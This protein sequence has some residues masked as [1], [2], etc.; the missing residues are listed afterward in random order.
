MVQKQIGHGAKKVLVLH[1]WFGASV[2]DEFFDDFD[3]DKFR[4]AIVHNPGYGSAK[5]Q[6]PAKDMTELAHTL[7]ATADGL[8]WREFHVIGHSYGG[9]AGLRMATIS[10]DRIQSLTAIAPVMPSGFDATA[11][12]NCNANEQTGPA[13]MS[14]YAKGPHAADG[15]RMIAAALDPILAKDQ[16]ALQELIDSTYHAISEETYK[17]YFLLWTGTSFTEEVKGLG[18]KSLFLIGKDDPF[19]AVNYVTP[20]AQSMVAGAVQIKEIDGGH[21][22]TVSGRA[23]SLD[24]IKSFLD[25]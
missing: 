17:Q 9:A 1:G 13:F 15:P 21:F 8:G 2:Y 22:L 10:P 6:T 18:T 25:Q 20:T 12:N 14:A 23:G 24:A 11:A 4:F 3:L 5:S 7:L 19:A 16:R